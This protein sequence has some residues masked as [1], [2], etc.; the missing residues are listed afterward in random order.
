MCGSV[1]RSTKVTLKRIVASEQMRACASTADFLW[2]SFLKWN[3]AFTHY[4]RF[5]RSRTVRVTLRRIEASEQMR[6]GG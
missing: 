2:E 4:G 3:N 6:A 1:L 5:L